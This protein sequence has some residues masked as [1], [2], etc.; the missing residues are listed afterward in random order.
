MLKKSLINHANF[1]LKHQSV[2]I[3]ILNG[4]SRLKLMCLAILLV[5][6]L[7]NRLWIVKIDGIWWPTIYV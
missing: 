3:L 7:V 1:L 6:F 5:E 4:T 2:N